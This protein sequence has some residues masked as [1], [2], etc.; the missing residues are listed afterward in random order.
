MQYAKQSRPAESPLSESDTYI[1]EHAY[2]G[3]HDS[4]YCIVAQFLSYRRSKVLLRYYVVLCYPK[5]GI[6]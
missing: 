6:Y 2:C 1:Y 5:L 3:Y 4:K